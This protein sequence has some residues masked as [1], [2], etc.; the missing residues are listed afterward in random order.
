MSSGIREGP[1]AESPSFIRCVFL[2]KL[3]HELPSKQMDFKRHS[4]KNWMTRQQLGISQISLGLT[5]ATRFQPQT[6][7]F[8]RWKLML[9]DEIPPRPIGDL[10]NN[11][12]RAE[13]GRVSRNPNVL[14]IIKFSRT[15][16]VWGADFT[17]ICIPEPKY[18]QKPVPWKTVRFKDLPWYSWRFKNLDLKNPAFV[19][20]L[21]RKAGF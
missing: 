2:R 8:R 11:Q 10:P 18:A 12:N 7:I 16:Q 9:M 14:K 20:S 17:K 3:D 1:Q 15:S 21:L 4:K 6:L 19:R 5:S 13:Y